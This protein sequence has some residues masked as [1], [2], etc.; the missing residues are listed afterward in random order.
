MRKPT[1]YKHRGKWYAR[2]WIAEEGKYRSRCLDV[3]VEGI[4]ERRREAEDAADR[5]EV[6]LRAP[7]PLPLPSPPEACV[8]S[9]PLYDYTAGFWRSDSEYVKEKALLDKKPISK[10]YLLSNRR[11]IETKV[12]P[13]PGFEGIT[14]GGLSKVLIRQWKLWL[15]EQGYS[16]KTIND[17]MKSI[18]VPIRRAVDDD[19]LSVN[20]F[21]GVRSAPHKEKKRGVLTPSEIRRLVKTP[22][23]NPHSR[24]AV[25]L[26]LYCSMR[27]GEVRGLQWG[28]ISD[29]I[30]HIRHNWQEG[31]GI[32]PCKCG[33][34]G[35]VPMPRI[36]ADLLN[37][38][39]ATA[40]LTG[41][42][43]FVMSQKPYKPA[44][45]E[46]LSKALRTE[47]ESIGIS[48]KQRKERNIVYHSMR[49][50]FVT[51]CRIAGFTPFETM[52]LSRHKD[53]KMLERY[54]HGQEALEA[55][56]IKQMGNRFERFFLP[57]A[58][59]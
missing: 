38:V 34:E 5:I 12:K 6:T 2:F 1:L 33:S 36:V 24:L 19:L 18:K 57:E 26:S 47:L 29:G 51:A 31:E 23:T 16:G 54:T 46:V 56:D 28:D 32:K 21:A 45:R 37:K 10:H 35:D 43:D 17:A 40:P 55:P 4:R 58:E 52:K 59:G 11:N 22:V 3:R 7:S 20:P 27:M 9:M 14:V 41:E 44:C 50:S 25:Y 53:P 42:N 15:A 30:I 13:F 8:S 39:H 49:H 48:E